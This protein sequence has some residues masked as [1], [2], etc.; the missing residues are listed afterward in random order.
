VPGPTAVLVIHGIG[1]QRP[2]QTL[3]QFA[4]TLALTYSGLGTP[5]TLSR[6]VRS[7][8]MPDGS[9][10]ADPFV[11]MNREGS[12]HPLDVYEYYWANLTEDRATAADVQEWLAG[13]VED[14]E[15]SR[16]E[17]A[18]RGRAVCDRSV[19]FGAG[20]GA[21]H[22]WRYSTFLTLLPRLAP[23][24]VGLLKRLGRWAGRLPFGGGPIGARVRALQEALEDVLANVIGDLVIYNTTDVRSKFHGIRAAILDGAVRAVR[25][26]V[27]PSVEAG[28]GHA[29]WA[30][31][32][33]ILAGH[34]LGSQVAY[35]AL[36]RLNRLIAKGE[37]AG[38]DRRGL[39]FAGSIRGF[40]G[41]PRRISDLLG[42][43]V[44]LGSPLDKIAFFLEGGSPGA[45][46]RRALDLDLAFKRRQWPA[47]APSGTGV[48][49]LVPRLLDDVPWL[50]YFDRRDYVSGALDY[51][52]KVTNV[53]CRFG[54]GFFTHSRYWRSE[55]LFRELMKEMLHRPAC[56]G[57]GDPAPAAA[58]A[59]LYAADDRLA[60]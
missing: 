5:V 22:A 52:E 32:R 57:L 4:Q 20:D 12:P 51:Y 47:A 7:R 9:H 31:G 41:R 34:S 36:G 18:A 42:G 49:P 33:V 24:A 44:T 14:A 11:R 29:S 55:T 30:Y 1:N 10:A 50:N 58:P 38:F 59:P 46:R 16:D 39:A 3:D 19:F 37:I 40:G 35:D 48:E 2:R 25:R 21:F 17:K 28:R 54:S 23:A 6:G 56:E 15:A 45:G 8:R 26:L 27:E 43:L 60:A 13:A 53:D